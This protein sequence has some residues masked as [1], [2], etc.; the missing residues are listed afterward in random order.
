MANHLMLEA[1]M[2]AESL[3]RLRSELLALSEADRAELAHDLIASLD[4]PRENGVEEAWGLEILRRIREIDSG[5]A[6]LV[7]RAE[8]RRRIQAKLGP[9]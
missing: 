1:S 2:A 3:E 8:L 9:Q 7:D 5:Q 4:E 6:T